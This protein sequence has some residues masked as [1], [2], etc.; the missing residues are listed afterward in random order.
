MPAGV[1]TLGIL[2]IWKR[3]F[4]HESGSNKVSIVVITNGTNDSQKALMVDGGRIEI[5]KS[6]S[7]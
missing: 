2:H 7:I 5:D 6:Q 1:L 4:T 3:P